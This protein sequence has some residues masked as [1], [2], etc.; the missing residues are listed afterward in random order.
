M[1][2]VGIVNFGRYAQYYREQIGVSPSTTLKA[3]DQ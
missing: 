1:V 2:N 3:R